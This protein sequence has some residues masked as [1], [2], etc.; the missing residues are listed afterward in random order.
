MMM[1]ERLR[2]AH[3][4][5]E[6]YMRRLGE[7]LRPPGIEIAPVLQALSRVLAE[8]VVAPIDLPPFDRAAMDGYAVRAED[9]YGARQ[10]RPVKLKLVGRVLAGE[11][12][13]HIHL[14]PGECVEIATGAMMP[15]G[16]NAVVR[17]EHARRRGDDVV[18]IYAP[19]PAGSCVDEAGRDV[20]RGSV[21]L[22]RGRVLRIPDVAL[23]LALGLKE[24]AVFKK[25]R[26]GVLSIGDELS[27]ALCPA[28]PGKIRDVDRPM[29]ILMLEQL[30]ALPIDLGIAPD[31]V[32]DVRKAISK[33]L[34]MCDA[35][36]T[37]G[38]ASLGPADVAV[39]AVEGLSEAEVLVRRVAMR[40]GRPVALCVVRE[41]PVI[42]LPGPPVACYI[43]F[44][45][46][47]KPVL[48]LLMGVSPDLKPV[49]PMARARLGK[50]LPSRVGFMDIVRVR[51]RSRPDG[52]LLAEPIALRGAGMLSSLVRANA[53]LAIPAELDV[54][55]KGAEVD[56][57]LIA[58]PEL[59]EA[60]EAMR[61]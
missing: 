48:L 1:A 3:E 31:D 11:D 27:D 25:P 46:F 20:K 56:V 4:A 12:S 51:L 44:H 29:L 42:C 21:V 16:A 41:K 34:D 28:G 24:V 54:L 15:E 60:E 39:K 10:D 18:E 61:A 30:G 8:D 17:A 6:S 57:L 36:L 40:P 2:P 49:W 14:G 33:G 47:V 50:K 52:S 58:C 37:V 13:S 19:V 55:E 9:T 7:T 23:L 43:A 59:I 53:I 5:L 26:I 32:G 22:K 38:G 35:I 45:F